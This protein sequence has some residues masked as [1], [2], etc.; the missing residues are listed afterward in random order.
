V[1]LF[2]LLGGIGAAMGVAAIGRAVRSRHQDPDAPAAPAPSA[3]PVSTP[4]TEWPVDREPPRATTREHDVADDSPAGITKPS[5]ADW[6]KALA[7]GC[8]ASGIQLAYALKWV[9]MES[10]GNPCTIGYPPA[11]GPDGLPL[12]MGIGQFYNPDD[13]QRLHL[14]G[15]ELR[16]YCVPGDQH[17]TVYKGK[18][19]RGFSQLMSR[20]ITLPEMQKQANGTVELIVRSMASASRDLG[21]VGAGPSWS[22]GHRAFWALTKLQHGLPALSR[23]GLPLVK[24]LLGRSP[25]SWSEFADALAKVKFSNEI[26]IKH[27][28]DFPRIL[29]NAWECSSAFTAQE[30]A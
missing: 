16:A 15:V 17:E 6:A 11:R 18:V 13:L 4:V 26:E 29:D 5:T 30:V 23:Q 28:A 1:L 7:P 2:Y 19:I 24:G 25:S 9:A 20:P 22:P 21:S 8:V 10:A 27:R 14:T 3:T 12:E